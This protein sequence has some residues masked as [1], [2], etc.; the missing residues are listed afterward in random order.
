MPH[1]PKPF[2]RNSINLTRH[3]RQWRTVRADELVDGDRVQG[4][5]LVSGREEP[6][7]GQV[8]MVLEGQRVTFPVEFEMVAFVLTEA[9]R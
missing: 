1:L 8:A 6:C 5:G 9:G 3:G 7:R 2:R 4:R